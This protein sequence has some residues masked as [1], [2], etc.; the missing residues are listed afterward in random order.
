MSGA[1]AASPAAVTDDDVQQY[2]AQ[3]VDE[4]KDACS[5]G[6][7]EHKFEPVVAGPTIGNHVMTSLINKCV[8]STQQGQV[9]QMNNTD[10]FHNGGS[11][12]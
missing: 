12:C 5:K 10:L 6:F 3:S 8:T 1:A 11:A 4:Y 2:L 7:A 9:T